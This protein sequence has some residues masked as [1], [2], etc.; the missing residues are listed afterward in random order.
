MSSD[1][2]IPLQR[3]F[4]AAVKRAKKAAANEGLRLSSLTFG[5]V[6]LSFVPPP[7]S[8]ERN[9]WDEDEEHGNN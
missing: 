9:E 6:S 3:E 2:K 8:S 1:P 5:G 4:N 7:A